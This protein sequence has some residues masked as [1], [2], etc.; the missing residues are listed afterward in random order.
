MISDHE[1]TLKEYKSAIELNRKLSVNAN[2]FQKHKFLL[3]Y[4]VIEKDEQNVIVD[5]LG[6]EDATEIGF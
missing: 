3:L 1:K 4:S 2:K 5:D 6:R